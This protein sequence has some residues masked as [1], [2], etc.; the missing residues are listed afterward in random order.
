[1]KAF[2]F[3][4]SG[5]EYFKI[6]IVNILLT[7]VTLGLYYP[8]AKVRN[9]RYIYGNS[10]LE[11]RNFDYHATG[12][13]LF[14]GYLISMALLITYI[15]IQQI[16][17]IGGAIV[18]LLFFL[19]LPWIVWRSLKFSM[20]MTSF[21]NVR[22]GFDGNL[23]GAYF[24][25]MLLPILFFLAL[26]SGPLF[27]GILTAVLGLNFGASAVILGTIAFIAGIALAVYMFSYLKKRNISYVLDSSRYGQGQFSTNLETSAL[28]KI[29]LKTVGLFILSLIGYMVLV[30]IIATVTGVSSDLLA[31]S[32]SLEDPEA[33]GEIFNSGG[34]IGLV[35]MVYAG[36]IIISILVF[37]YSFSRQR[38]YIL[39]NTLLDDKIKLASTLKAMPLA[40]I[41]IS[42]FLAIIFSLGL[43]IPWATVRLT[44]FVLQHTEIDTSVGLNDYITKQEE[45][46]SSLGEQLGD[47]FDVDVGLGI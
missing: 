42:N 38:A 3:E 35:A 31:I 41:S 44:R 26:Y 28:V 22:F 47:A 4:G 29:F 32:G 23:G 12:K 6:W 16:S 33:I 9:K 20:R 15:V 8:W 19:A 25:Y 24:N 46:Q 36:F 45:E 7:I 37:S 40:W 10:T 39:A 14:V 17:P 18:F 34:I 43:A 27:I 5:L 1:M 21:S 13:Q 30:G 2:S 11:N